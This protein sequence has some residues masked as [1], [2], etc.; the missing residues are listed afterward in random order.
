MKLHQL[1]MYQNK[2]KPFAERLK[3]LREANA[4]KRAWL[5][6]VDKAGLP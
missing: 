1:A 5:S 6:R 2:E 4:K 3:R